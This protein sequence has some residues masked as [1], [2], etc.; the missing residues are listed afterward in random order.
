MAFALPLRTVGSCTVV[1]LPDEIDLT[2]DAVIRRQL[3]DLVTPDLPGL[4]VDMSATVF[5]GL[6]GVA[7]V[8]EVCGRAGALGRWVCVVATHRQ[9]RRAL[10]LSAFE[11]AVPILTTVEEAVLGRDGGLRPSCG[12]ADAGRVRADEPR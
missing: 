5:C 9:V 1:Q 3:L 10:Q 12:R 8:A 7:A 4:V 11:A 6:R 2:N